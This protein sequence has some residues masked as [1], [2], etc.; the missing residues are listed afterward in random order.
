[1]GGGLSGLTKAFYIKNFFPKAHI[2]L[3]E[4]SNRIGGM[5]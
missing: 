5:M 1:V 3:I 4:Q 2:T